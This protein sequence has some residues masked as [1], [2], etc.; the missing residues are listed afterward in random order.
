V[1]SVLPDLKLGW[2]NLIR[3]NIYY[4]GLTTLSQTLTPLLVP[5]L[6]QQFVGVSQQGT[7]YGNLRLWTLM[8]ALLV[9]SLMGSIS[10]RST[11][12]WG[13]RRP[14]IVVGTLINLVL[15]VLVGFSSALSG[16]TGYWILFSL[17]ILIMIATN[18]AHG[19]LQGF[20]PD[21][22]PRQQRGLASG[23]KA[24]FEV[25][26]P[27]ILVAF[28]IGPLIANN[29]IWFALG[30]LISIQL[31][32]MLL[33][34]QIKE[35]PPAPNSQPTDWQP[36]L[37]LVMMTIVFTTIILLLG[38]SASYLRNIF[39]RNLPLSSAVV[40]VGSIGLVSMVL[41]IGIGVIISV[42]VGLGKVAFYANPDFSWWV[43]SRLAYLTG[44]IN[45]AGFAVFFLQ[46]RLGFAQER[47]AGPASIVLLIVGIFI[48]VTAIPS[49]WV[50]D[51]LGYKWVLVASGVL[52][53]SGVVLIIIS[54]N[55]LS[56]YVGAVLVGLATGN[57]YTT[58][59]AL[60]TQLVPGNQA[61]LFLGISNLAGAGA[62][63][64]GAFIGGPVAD[65]F[66]RAYPNSSGIGYVVLFGIFGILFILSTFALK[67]VGNR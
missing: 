36:F 15:I 65:Y 21:L 54:N 13:K 51:R 41:A 9:Q 6:V 32:V 39:G 61:G 53:A 48:L 11:V 16:E 38:W 49:G 45:L 44:S 58:N 47:A 7:A 3:I 28:T 34:I 43:V 17:I 20:I 8:V 19:A 23:I 5:L 56:V 64:V 52:A 63:A 27:L 37:R 33:T 35:N 30:V 1:K 59:W 50:A 67:F 2:G 10:D 26:L 57:F 18:T 55:L 14:F 46:E 66:T 25:P 22:V 62:G 40:I 60:G 12:H 31:I 42:R 4:L 24:I 29:Q